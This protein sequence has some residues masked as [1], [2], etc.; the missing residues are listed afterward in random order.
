MHP[1]GVHG[2]KPVLLLIA[3]LPSLIVCNLM[4][5]ERKWPAKNQ[6]PKTVETQV[7]ANSRKL[8]P[9]NKSVVDMVDML[10]HQHPFRGS[11]SR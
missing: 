9:T 4:E 3:V 11:R 7:L 8:P 2:T 1:F 10:T 6:K 5:S